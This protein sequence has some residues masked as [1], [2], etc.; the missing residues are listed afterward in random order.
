M[1]RRHPG[2]TIV[3]KAHQQQSASAGGQLNSVDHPE[4]FL[5][6]GTQH[7]IERHYLRSANARAAN[8]H[9]TFDR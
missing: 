7:G 8:P 4:G 3:A 2:V 1:R 5:I 6:A 9:S